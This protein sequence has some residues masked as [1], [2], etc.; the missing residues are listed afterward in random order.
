[1]NL[2][3][4]LLR[5][6]VEKFYRCEGFGTLFGTLSSESSPAVQAKPGGFR[7][8]PRRV[9]TGRSRVTSTESTRNVRS[10]GKRS[11]KVARTT[12]SLHLQVQLSAIAADFTSTQRDLTMIAVPGYPKVFAPSDVILR[13]PLPATQGSPLVSLHPGLK[14]KFEI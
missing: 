3:S 1:M 10:S 14:L 12:V 6:F 5:R 7:R 4:I 2:E 13:H 8:I 11:L 9:R